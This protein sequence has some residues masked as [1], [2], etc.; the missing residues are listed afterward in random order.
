MSDTFIIGQRVKIYFT[1]GDII[2]G[3]LVHMPQGPGDTVYIKLGD[4]LK[5]INMNASTVEY[6]EQD[7]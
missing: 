1:N 3:V 7:G 4:T 6:M 5:A 2:T